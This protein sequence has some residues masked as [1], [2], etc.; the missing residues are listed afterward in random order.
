MKTK[1]IIIT[2][3][4]MLICTLLICSVHS[5]RSAPVKFISCSDPDGTIIP[6]YQ[7]KVKYQYRGVEKCASECHNNEKAGFQY[8]IWK[9]S[10]H[11]NAYRVLLEQKAKK[12]A[13]KAHISSN[14]WESAE[15]L[16]CHTTAGNLDKSFLLVTYHNEDGVTC[17]ACHK[18]P[19][20]P[21][22]FLPK[23]ENC[24]ECHDGASH[25]M[26]KFDFTKGSAKFAHPMANKQQKPAS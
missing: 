12:Y 2:S 17:E 6:A 4:A 11:A 5:Y 1:K 15:C 18:H 23:E 19:Y 7:E 3:G 16:K 24:R 10:P 13:K 9:K 26:N 8:D 22:T 20:V 25:K 21:K 14:P